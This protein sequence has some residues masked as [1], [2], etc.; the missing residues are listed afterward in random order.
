MS[1]LVE[2]IKTVWL[3]TLQQITLI[4]LGK[5]KENSIFKWESF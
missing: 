1:A 3:A 5:K 2:I 4:V